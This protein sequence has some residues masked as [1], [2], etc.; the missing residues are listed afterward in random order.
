MKSIELILSDLRPISEFY[1]SMCSE[2]KSQHA[3]GPF[4][5]IIQA[6]MDEIQKFFCELFR[7]IVDIYDTKYEVNP[8]NI[9][10]Y[11]GYK[12]NFSFC[13]LVVQRLSLTLK[14]PFSP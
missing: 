9:K 4:F 5:A 14:N 10:W 11:G 13:F 1:K 7:I 12:Q 8:V 6:V 2:T 3:L